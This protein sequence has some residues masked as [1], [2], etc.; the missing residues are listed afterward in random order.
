M[1]IIPA[2]FHQFMSGWYAC[3]NMLQDSHVNT[4]YSRNFNICSE[5]FFSAISKF[6]FE[7]RQ[8]VFTNHWMY[9]YILCFVLYQL[10]FKKTTCFFSYFVLVHFQFTLTYEKLITVENLYNGLPIMG[11]FQFKY[12]PNVNR[13]TWIVI[14]Y[15]HMFNVL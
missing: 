12:N 10:N 9:T 7:K 3:K 6:V 5:F 14:L 2:T 4:V 1:L 15:E 11:Y 8:Q 13:K